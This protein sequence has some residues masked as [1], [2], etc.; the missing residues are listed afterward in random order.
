[1]RPRHRGHPGYAG[2]HEASARLAG[3]TLQAAQALLDGSAVRAVNFS[4]GMHHAFADRASGFCV[5]NDCAVGIHRLLEAGS[6][7]CST[8]TWTATTATAPSRSSGTIPA[9]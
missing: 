7:A 8:W 3:G 9:S 2:I 4:G 1:M 6:P 5:Y